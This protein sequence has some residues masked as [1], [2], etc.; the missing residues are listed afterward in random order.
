VCLALFAG[1]ALGVYFGLVCGIIGG[2]LGLG[3]GI[4]GGGGRVS[5]LILLAVVVRGGSRCS[6]GVSSR[7]KF[8]F[9]L[10]DDTF[11]VWR[12]VA[13]ILFTTT[14]II[15]GGGRISALALLAGC[16]IIGVVDVV[17]AASVQ[18]FIAS[19][20]GGGRVHVC[21]TFGVV[22]AVIIVIVVVLVGGRLVAP[23]RFI[24]RIVAVIA[25]DAVTVIIVGYVHFA[26]ASKAR[27]QVRS[28]RT[29]RRRGQHGRKKLARFDWGGC[30]VPVQIQP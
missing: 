26:S 9:G 6:D 10:V 3:I 29:R 12:V 5:A 19:L 21:I 28:S 20:I 4:T 23:P 13:T 2:G 1:A 8:G 25:A 18:I 30:I 7:I 11:F 15:G 27:P 17:R 22:V 16:S 14:A 24:R